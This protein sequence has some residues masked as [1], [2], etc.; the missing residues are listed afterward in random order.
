MTEPWMRQAESLIG[1]AEIAGAADAPEVLKLFAESGHPEIRDDE[2]AWCAAFVGAMLAR[3][4]YAGTGKLN[5]RSYLEWGE[6]LREPRP[7]CV[8]VFKRGNSS[9]QG[10][11]AFFVGRTKTHIQVLGGNQGNQ[12]SIASYKKADLLGYRWPVKRLADAEEP[13]AEA[14]EIRA[15]QSRLHELGYPEV[16]MVDGKIGPK[17]RGAMNSFRDDN[18]LPMQAKDTFR[19]TPEDHA[20]LARA[21][22]RVVNREGME[23]ED[24][25]ILADARA[26]QTVAGTVAAAGGAVGLASV[27]QAVAGA[28]GPLG[29]VASALEPLKEWGPTVLIVLAIAGGIALFLWSRRTKRNEIAAFREGRVT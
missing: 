1:V 17:F 2:T 12:V 26:G 22:P 9:W 10:H 18:G 6:K 24:S 16:G 20:A 27:T 23:P 13:E 19:I 29:A 11:V 3:A 14:D 7:G 25:E 8:V 15:V 28:A 21:R 4:G 5:A